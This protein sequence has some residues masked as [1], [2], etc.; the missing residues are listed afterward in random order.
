VRCDG[1]IARGDQV[2]V[3]ARRGLTLMVEPVAPLAASS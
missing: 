1:G 3:I 2:R